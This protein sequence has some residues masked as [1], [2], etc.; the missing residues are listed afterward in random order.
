VVFG[1]ISQKTGRC[2]QNVAIDDP[3]AYAAM[4]L[5]L[6]LERRGITIAGEASAL[7]HDSRILGN[8][9]TERPDD[10]G[11]LR[12][13]FSH[14]HGIVECSAQRAANPGLLAEP[15]QMELASHLSM[16]LLADLTYTNKVSQNLHAEVLL[17]DLGTAF[18]CAGAAQRDGLH[19]VR[20]YVL[21]A[22]VNPK[23]FVLYDGSG[24]SDHDLVTPRAF[25]TFLAFAAAQPWFE[26]WKATLPNGGA[27]GT[28]AARFKPPVHFS[29]SAKT[30]TLGESRALSGYLTTAAGQTLVFSILVDNHLPSS[31]ADRTIMDK[32]VTTIAGQPNP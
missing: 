22:G 12:G 19:I 10:D 5:K 15:P 4:A 25:T 1:D 24:L 2:S 8:V 27:D 16:P 23:D 13:V 9:F 11:F 28:L 6:A 26:A 20:E 29:I 21:F 7:H 30:G 31:S 32:I 18:S 3:A 14:P 17:R